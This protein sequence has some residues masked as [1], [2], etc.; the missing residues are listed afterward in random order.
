MLI[1][2]FQERIRHKEGQIYVFD[3]IRKRDILLTP[4][5]EVRQCL[6][7]YLI[8]EKKYSKSLIKIEGGL[9]VNALKKRTDI[10][11]YDSDSQPYLLIECKAPSVQLDAQTIKQAGNYNSE[12]KAPFLAISNGAQHF[13]FSID[14]ETKTSVQLADFPDPKKNK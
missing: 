14:F 12:I 7:D 5:E 10:I 3:P 9:R 1:K 4:E 2:L 11:I 8:L 13:C 6:L